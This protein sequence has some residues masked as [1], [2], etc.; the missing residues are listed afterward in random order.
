MQ[1]RRAPSH[2]G[3]RVNEEIMRELCEILRTVKDPRV[4]G[5]FVSIIAVDASADLKF[6]KI[7]Y[8]VMDADE[9]E[10]KKGLYSAVGYIRR[11]LAIRLNLRA[12]PELTFIRDTSIEHGAKISKILKDLT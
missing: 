7:Y 5:S 4:S 8:S 11:E 12:T 10:V 9:K 6:A 1:R 2:R 3:Q